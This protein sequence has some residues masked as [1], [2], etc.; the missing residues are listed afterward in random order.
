MLH[1]RARSGDATRPGEP[2]RLLNRTNGGDYA[3]R[4]RVT[5]LIMLLVIVGGGMWMGSLLAGTTKSRLAL[6][7]AVIH[8]WAENSRSTV[9]RMVRSMLGARLIDLPLLLLFGAVLTFS[10]WAFFEL[11][12]DV[13]MGDGVTG[14]DRAVYLW[15]QQHRHPGWDRLM[16]GVTELGDAN[17]AMPVAGA[18]IALLAALKFW[19]EA[20]F[21]CAAMI[22][23]AGFV[24]GLKRVIQRARP[25]D[26]YDGVAEY[27]FPSGH[28][29]MSI[30]LFGFLAFLLAVRATAGC[31]RIIYRASIVLVLLIGFSR[32]YL[33]AHWMSDVLAGFAFGLA[34][35]SVLAIAYLSRISA[36]EP[37]LLPVPTLAACLG[38]TLL[39]AGSWHMLRDHG[40]EL[41]RYSQGGL[42]PPVVRPMQIEP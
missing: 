4:P 8:A 20:M 24:A 12:E 35:N 22:G 38:M 14:L 11:L 16:V 5:L 33:G 3:T 41:R 17:V 19:R 7:A 10:L 39:L 32:V 37:R 36:A 6:F 40:A 13:I 21:L 1:M 30:V 29:G 31:R 26:I 15:L 25:V 23:A 9:G 34:W 18:A 27:S 42:L 2:I 28:A